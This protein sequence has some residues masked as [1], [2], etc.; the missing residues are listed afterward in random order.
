MIETTE[1]ETPTNGDLELRTQDAQALEEN[2]EPV[3]DACRDCHAKRDNVSAGIMRLEDIPELMSRAEVESFKGLTLQTRGKHIAAL[4]DLLAFYD[5]PEHDV[6]CSLRGGHRHGRGVVVRT[7]CELVICMGED[8]G[9]DSIIGYK[10]IRSRARRRRK[11][12]DQKRS[13]SGWAE[14]FAARIAPLRLQCRLR[15]KWRDV[16][17]VQLPTLEREL[18]ERYSLG[19]RGEEVTVKI[20]GSDSAM[21]PEELGGRVTADVRRLVGLSVVMPHPPQYDSLEAALSRFKSLERT[22]PAV[23]AP[24][25]QALDELARSAS[26]AATKVESWVRD[27]QA[28]VS[29]ENLRLALFALGR[30]SATVTQEPGGLRVSYMPGETGLLLL[31]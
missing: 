4:D 9:E 21:M 8:C 22:S 24:S 25:A 5:L 28:L 15:Q 19:A 11:F 13:L 29:V 31:A 3:C 23:D 2:R 18:K 6:H 12:R 7:L 17:H 14:G 20:A 1:T 16:L 10:E 27:T 26:K 30:D